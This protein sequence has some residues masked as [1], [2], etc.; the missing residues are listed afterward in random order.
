[1][2]RS[3]GEVRKID[4]MKKR[5]DFVENDGQALP[6]PSSRFLCVIGVDDDF[7]FHLVASNPALNSVP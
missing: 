6:A 1:M 5:A 2:K 7:V 4:S 3:R